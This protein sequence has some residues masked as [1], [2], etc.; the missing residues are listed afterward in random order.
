MIRCRTSVVIFGRTKDF[1]AELGP[2][3]RAN[4]VPMCRVHARTTS[5]PGPCQSLQFTIRACSRAKMHVFTVMRVET[6]RS[7]PS[8]S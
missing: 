3:I 8:A 5:D 7:S 1:R 6:W 2:D 4:T